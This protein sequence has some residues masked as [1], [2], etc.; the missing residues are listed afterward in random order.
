MPASALRPRLTDEWTIPA[1]AL[2]NR[3]DRCLRKLVPYRE[4]V[5]D[6]STCGFFVRIISKDAQHMTRQGPYLFEHFAGLAR[7]LG[8]FHLSN[9]V[10]LP[11]VTVISRQGKEYPEK[12]L[13]ALLQF[14]VV[15]QAYADMARQLQ[16]SG[17]YTVTPVTDAVT[18]EELIDFDDL[19]PEQQRALRGF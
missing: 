12:P 3:I 19:T 5:Y 13:P 1:E 7:M 14:N 9:G 10:D 4:L 17:L 15:T 18:Q 16:A 8:L 11:P 6:H 2:R